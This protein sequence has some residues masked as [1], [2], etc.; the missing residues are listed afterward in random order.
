MKADQSLRNY[1]VDHVIH[2]GFSYYKQPQNSQHK[3]GRQSTERLSRPFTNYWHISFGA[4]ITNNSHTLNILL[5][6]LSNFV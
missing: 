1:I 3:L 5:P 2:H 6:S 4:R